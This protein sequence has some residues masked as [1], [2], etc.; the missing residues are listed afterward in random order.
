ML[1]TCILHYIY[2]GGGEIR[3]KN[4][5]RGKFQVSRLGGG[6]YCEYHFGVMLGGFFG[7]FVCF[8]LLGMHRKGVSEV[9][10]YLRLQH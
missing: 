1:C 2:S 3:E 5:E 9:D 6:Y 10:K 7:L 4:K 8:L